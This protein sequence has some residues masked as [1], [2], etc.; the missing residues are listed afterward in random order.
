MGLLVDGVWTDQW[1]DTSKSGGRFERKD[2]AFRGTIT[3]D[4]AE[5]GRYHLYVSYACPWAHRV[6]IARKLKKLDT[7]VSFSSV[8][9]LML[10]HGW[11]FAEHGEHA[12]PLYRARVLHAIYTRADARYSGRVTVP[13]LWDKKR[14]TIVNNESSELLVLFDTAFAGLAPE[15]PSLYPAPLREDIDAVNARVYD[16]LNNGVYKCGFA[17][18]QEAYEEAL[19]PLFETL[20]WLEE[21]LAGRRWLV[22][23]TLTLADVRL[24]TTLVRFDAVYYAHFKCNLHRI[25]DRPNLAAFVR[26]FY[27]LPGVAETVR[28]AEVKRH[29]FGSHRG[30]NPTGIVPVGPILDFLV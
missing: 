17:T 24:F 12:D 21:R 22:G 28:I 23:D 26:A 19:G 16:T 25:V 13:V 18:T 6:L 3:N 27:A 2:S 5:A 1:Y 15:T 9:P 20:A 14:E 30:I 7:I 10:E 29:Y 4:D 8:E 11:T